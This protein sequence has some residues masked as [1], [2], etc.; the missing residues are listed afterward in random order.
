MH[1]SILFVYF[2]RPLATH[3]S[4]HKQKLTKP[5]KNLKRRFFEF[6]SLIANKIHNVWIR[7]KEGKIFLGILLKLW[8]Y[9][10]LERKHIIYQF[11][12]ILIVTWLNRIIICCFVYA[13]LD[14][15]MQ[16]KKLFKTWVILT[17]L[18][19]ISRYPCI[20]SKCPNIS[21]TQKGLCKSFMQAQSYCL[22]LNFSC[23]QQ[24]F[25]VHTFYHFETLHT[26]PEW[27]RF[28]QKLF[29]GGC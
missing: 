25:K 10:F 13:Q 15:E 1:I 29:W 28:V 7:Q 22:F 8:N 5:A 16:K 23:S 6:S 4:K 12:C 17:W 27:N 2:A 3:A 14:Q 9:V 18:L 11:C 24:T 20:L 19:D 26:G 21:C